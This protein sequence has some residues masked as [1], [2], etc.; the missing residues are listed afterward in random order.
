MTFRILT[1]IEYDRLEITSRSRSHRGLIWGKGLGAT[2]HFPITLPLYLK[3]IAVEFL[4]D[5][6]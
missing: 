6:S 2:S 5:L 4:M 3:A 1:G